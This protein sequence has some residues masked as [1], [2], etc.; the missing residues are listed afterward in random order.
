MPLHPRRTPCTLRLLGLAMGYGSLVVQRF[1]HE[2]NCPRPRAY[3]SR[4]QPMLGEPGYSVMP[5]GHATEAYLLAKMLGALIEPDLSKNPPRK[6]K[7]EAWVG[8][9]RDQLDRLAERIA[10]NRVVAGI[11]FP[12]D[13]VAGRLVGVTLAEFAL[14]RFSGATPWQPRTFDGLSV[15]ST[16][17]MEFEPAQQPLCGIQNHYY[18]IDPTKAV[19]ATPAH[20]ML[21]WLWGK[22]RSEWQ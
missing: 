18:K 11:H 22:A 16:P 20:P 13:N 14:A 10:T 5:S 7:Q 17:T 3:S 19:T 4:I 8:Q 2:L 1:K 15:G 12:I 9:A 21:V 6:A